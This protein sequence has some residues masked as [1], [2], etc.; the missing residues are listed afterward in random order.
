MLLKLSVT[1]SKNSYAR[2]LL[3]LPFRNSLQEVR[4]RRFYLSFQQMSKTDFHI[5]THLCLN[6]RPLKKCHKSDDKF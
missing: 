4:W 2:R 1:F 6:I 5:S 3:I